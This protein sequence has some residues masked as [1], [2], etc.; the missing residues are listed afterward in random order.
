M[1]TL[2]PSASATCLNKA[3]TGGEFPGS[4][5]SLHSQTGDQQDAAVMGQVGLEGEQA[6]GFDS[7]LLHGTRDHR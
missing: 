7:G 5:R 1:W 6:V 3:R 4:Q 2:A